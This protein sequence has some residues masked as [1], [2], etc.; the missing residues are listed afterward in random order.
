MPSRAPSGRDHAVGPLIGP[1]HAAAI[2]RDL[3]HREEGFAS[4][5]GRSNLELERPRKIIHVD[6]DA[7]YTSVE[8]C[9][10]PALSAWLSLSVGQGN[11]VS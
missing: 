7:F 3:N 1:D 4:A 9:A 5:L 6:M 10:H 8:Q 2:D 11:L